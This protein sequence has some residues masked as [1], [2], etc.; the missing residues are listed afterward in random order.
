VQS[1]AFRRLNALEKSMS[2]RLFERGASGYAPSAAGRRVIA[3]AER[4]AEAADE[5]E[6]AVT[7]LDTRLTGMV[8]VTTTDSVAHTLL[9]PA[10]GGFLAVNPGLAVEVTIENRILALT[11]READVALRSQRVTEPELFGRKLSGIA[12]TVYAARAYLARHKA[13]REPADVAKHAVIGWDE[14]GAAAPAPAW[15]ERAAGSKPPVYRANSIV[16][17]LHAA[18]AGIGLAL[19]PCFLGDCSA[20]LLRVLPPPA[21][22]TRELW[23][24]THR[25][26]RRTARVRALMK[27]V[28]VAIAR[29]RPLL[30]GTRPAR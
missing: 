13:P 21:E 24:A 27:F 4:M 12:W 2:V 23:I 17:Q 11:R 26:L 14:A 9:T 6:R 22:L 16:N 8:R 29:E 15:L 3:A 18:E 7:G 20:P 19:L 30:E 5:A 1:T 10:L 28:G 25:D